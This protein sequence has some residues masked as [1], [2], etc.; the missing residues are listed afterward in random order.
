MLLRTK[1]ILGFSLVLLLTAITG[2]SAMYLTSVMSAASSMA[3]DIDNS[4]SLMQAGL[5]S[6]VRY[7]AFNDE[8]DAELAKRL[9]TESRSLAQR[10]SQSN[11]DPALAATFA[12]TLAL[13]DKVLGEF[14]Q[15][16]AENR[17]VNASLAQAAALYDKMRNRYD[18]LLENVEALVRSLLDQDNISLLVRLN[19][20]RDIINEQVRAGL[21][22]YTMFSSGEAEQTVMTAITKSQEEMRGTVPMFKVRENRAMFESL[23]ASYDEYCDHAVSYLH[24][25]SALGD[26]QRAFRADL[27]KFGGLLEQLSLAGINAVQEADDTANAAA[28]V[29]LALALTAGVATALFISSN[30]MRQLGK[31]PGQLNI[32]AGRV[33]NGDYDIDDGSRKLGVYGALVEMVGA[34]RKNID[35]ATQESENAREQSARA[36]EAMKE[37]EAAGAD[38]RAKR[39]GMLVVAERLEEVS[40]VVSSASTELAAQIEQSERGAAEQ[41]ARV[42][43]TATAMEEMNSTV[44]EVARNAGNASEVSASTREKAEHGAAVVQE[45]VASIQGVQEAS[46]ALKDD[47]AALDDNARAI[48]QIMAVI[49]DIADQTNLLALNAA[50]EAARAGEA[51]RGFAVVA[52]EVRKLAEKTMASTTDVGNAIKAIQ[53]SA[54]KSMDQVDL[55]VGN[56]EKA[57]EL[58]IRSGDALREIVGMVDDTADQVRGIAA[59]SEQ[60]S[61]SSEEINKSIM[62][63]NTIAG[64]TAS[65]MQEAARAVSELAEQA[66]VLTGLIRELKNA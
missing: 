32:L 20:I 13:A 14:E 51:G 29:L 62:Q 1:I 45:V 23:L 58:A 52:D 53:D 22:A 9:L 35:M 30:V 54:A 34:L 63:V 59:A 26:L 24:E 19:G 31:D 47:M 18:K 50:I 38:A 57:T 27:D 64:E 56:I 60:Q 49:S 66:Q 28:M 6:T 2:V 15:L 41:A 7:T 16:R 42:T 21:L 61:A 11:T 40:N 3:G 8:A 39:D 10:A 4:R 65:A 48:S 37:A 5:V 33:V 36:Q 46:V 44:L 12:E 17:K 25:Q 55:T 43:E